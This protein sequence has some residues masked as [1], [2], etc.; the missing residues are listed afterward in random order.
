MKP[1]NLEKALAGDPVVTR[2]GRIVK[3]VHYDLLDIQL[4]ALRGIVYK[5]LICSATYIIGRWTSDGGHWG[6]NEGN[7]SF[8][9]LFMSVKKVKRWLWIHNENMDTASSLFN[10]KD[11]LLQKIAY[12]EHLGQIIEVEIEEI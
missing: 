5:P 8:L 1:F 9:D 10:S 7:D 3:G 2:D 12:R 11:E 6:E 4:I